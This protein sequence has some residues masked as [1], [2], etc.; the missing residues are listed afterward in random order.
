MILNYFIFKWAEHSNDTLALTNNIQ[1]PNEQ[2]FDKLS[3]EKEFFEK[4]QK[5]IP[6]QIVSK[7]YF[8]IS[9]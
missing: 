8:L 7:F 4:N 5:A 3:Y 6:K 9:K 2:Q 1:H